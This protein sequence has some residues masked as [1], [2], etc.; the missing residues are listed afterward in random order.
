[1]YVK[2]Q[3]SFYN[4]VAEIRTS[5]QPNEL[6]KELKRTEKELGRSRTYQR[7]SPR[8]ID[9]DIL[10]YGGRELSISD[11]SFPLDIPHTRLKERQFVLRPLADIAP[12]LEIPGVG[13]VCDIL[14]EASEK[15]NHRC[16]SQ[17]VCRV[18]PLRNGRQLIWG[19]RTLLMGIIN[20]TPDSFSD[21]G[22]H[23]PVSQAIEQ[24]R[25][26]LDADFDV[27]DVSCTKLLYNP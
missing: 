4:T 19:H 8:T 2:S 26:F 25:R 3:P 20:V 21:G 1:M 15:D 6:L 7:Y 5:L 16:E 11:T 23:I 13:L 22:K 17:G 10:M 18:T 14:R 9:L 12:T 27:L 24:A